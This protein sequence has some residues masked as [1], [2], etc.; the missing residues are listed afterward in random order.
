MI[1]GATVPRKLGTYPDLFHADAM[2]AT[3]FWTDLSSQK[4]TYNAPQLVLNM[5]E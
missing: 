5:Q 4:I 2:D 1:G 3:F